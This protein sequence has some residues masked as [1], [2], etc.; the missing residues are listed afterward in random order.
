MFTAVATLGSFVLAVSYLVFRSHK[1][2]P[3]LGVEGLIGEVG[4]VR[5]KLAPRGSIFVHGETW[6][7][8]ADDE[9]GSG[10]RVEVIGIDRMVLRVRRA[11][12]RNRSAG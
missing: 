9:I 5:E 4:I 12:A 1:S 11:Q 10:D 2:K 6:K 7:A 3:A 8:E